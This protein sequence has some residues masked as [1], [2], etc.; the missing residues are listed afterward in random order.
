MDLRCEFAPWICAIGL[1]YQSALSV[2]TKNGMISRG[3][4]MRLVH[5][6]RGW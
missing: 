6:S 1:H 4:Q 2:C 3:V 5:G